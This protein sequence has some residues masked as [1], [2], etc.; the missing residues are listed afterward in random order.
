[1]EGL[2]ISIICRRLVKPGCHPERSEGSPYKG[3]NRLREILLRQSA[4]QN[5]KFNCFFK[6][7]KMASSVDA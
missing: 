3:N 1:M 2:F 5:D 6:S 7:Q 4:D